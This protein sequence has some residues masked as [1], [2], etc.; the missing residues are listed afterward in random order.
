ME[1]FV[2]VHS[3]RTKAGKVIENSVFKLIAQPQRNDFGLYIVVDGTGH[4]DLRNGNTRLY[5]DDISHYEPVD[6][7]TAERINRAAETDTVKNSTDAELAAELRDTF[8]ILEEMTKAVACNVVKGLVVSGPAGVGKSY[9]VEATLVKQLS[10]LQLLRSGE[11]QY[12]IISGGMSASVL[13]EKLYEYREEGQVLVFD[14]CDNILYDEDSL[15][16]LKAALD[17]RKTRR[18]S[19]NTRSIHLE[20]REIP[21]TFE[22]R[23]G[24]IFIT[25]VDFNNVKSARISN[26]LEAIVSR[27]H[28]MSLGMTTTREK[29]VRIKDVIAR[30]DM[31]SEY[32]FAAN[33]EQEVLDYITSNATRLREISLRTVLK[34][35]DLR[36]AMPA[37]WVK[38]ADRNVLRSA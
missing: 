12:E 19:W 3:A 31:L 4:D 6:R 18:I 28:Y 16:V 23:G 32:K 8:D 33:E 38:F 27:C 7:K 29:I 11:A 13:F 24:I 22:Y 26:H 30:N 2:R 9:T 34:V 1:T 25:N 37:N 21:N 36:K 20:K 35:A 14:D 5:I 17:S 15:N 10:M